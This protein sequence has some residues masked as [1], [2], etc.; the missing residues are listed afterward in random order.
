MKALA[1]DFD[2]VICNS[3]REAM[4]VALRT[5]VQLEPG[6]AL[7]EHLD[8]IECLAGRATED[9]EQHPLLR[10]AAPLIP[11]GNRAEDYGVALSALDSGLELEDQAAYDAYLASRPIGWLQRFHAEF[12]RQRHAF[13]ADDPGHWLALH[14]PYPQVISLLR[15][16]GA[17]VELA[18]ATAKDG[19]SVRRLLERYGIADLFPPARLLDK[20]TG[21]TK[22]AHLKE[23]ASRLG[24]GLD[25]ITFVD[26]KLN[27][28]ESVAP[29]GVRCV[30]AAWGYNA[31]REQQRARQLGITVADLDEAEQALLGP[32]PDTALTAPGPPGP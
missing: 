17:E 12:Y 9:L 23:L 5:Y 8:S 19:R 28:L 10:R 1:L 4:V 22:T 21:V 15:R 6:S 32:P 7:V 2:G 3:L 13:Q 27:H 18:I 11:L 14:R 31:E 29:L 16:R 26:D 24:I 25:Q 20:E 30:L